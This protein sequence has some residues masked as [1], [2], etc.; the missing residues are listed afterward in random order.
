MQARRTLRFL[1]VL[2]WCL[3]L[4][5][6]ALSIVLEDKLPPLLRTY[7]LEQATRTR[8]TTDNVVVI[9]LWVLVSAYMTASVALFLLR[10]WGA[11][12]Y[13]V[14]EVLS[15]VVIG[16]GI[17]GPTVNH[18]IEQVVSSMGALTVGAILAIAFGTDVLL[19]G[20][21]GQRSRVRQ[22]LG[23]ESPEP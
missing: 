13:L 18:P 17:I 10:R 19:P 5:G 9:G 11:W 20:R 15:L 6:V 22:A 7:V 12:L 14:V 2:S 23:A 16:S 21:Y 4:A 8:G 3:A 1:I